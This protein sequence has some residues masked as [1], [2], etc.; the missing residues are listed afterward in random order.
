MTPDTRTTENPEPGSPVEVIWIDSATKHGWQLPE[1]LPND[2][3][4]HARTVGIYV[5]TSE[6]GVTV[7]LGSGQDGDYLCPQVIPKV[8]IRSIAILGGTGDE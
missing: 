2:E 7:A 1:Q 5:G 6:G 8:A 4:M 3:D